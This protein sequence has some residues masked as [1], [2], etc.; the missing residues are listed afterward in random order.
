METDI[1][2]LLISGG[3]FARPT[4]TQFIDVGRFSVLREG[5]GG[6]GGGGFGGGRWDGGGVANH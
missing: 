6:G 4:F 5:W 3:M 1:S 2:R